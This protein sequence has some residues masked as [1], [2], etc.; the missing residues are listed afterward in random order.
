MEYPANILV[1]I[2][3]PLP[4]FRRTCPNQLD[5]LISSQV[6]AILFLGAVVPVLMHAKIC[7]SIPPAVRIGRAGGRA[8]YQSSLVQVIFVIHTGG[9]PVI[10]CDR[11]FIAEKIR[12]HAV[13]RNRVLA[14]KH[15]GGKAAIKGS[16]LPSG[17]LLCDGG[18]L[19]GSA[20]QR[21]QHIEHG[22]AAQIGVC[23]QVNKRAVKAHL[24]PGQPLVEVCPLRRPQGV[25]IDETAE[26]VLAAQGNAIAVAF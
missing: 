15:A 4:L 20:D 14:D 23:H 22:L 13:N 19:A 18:P 3:H 6:P 9:G 16:L 2:K 10:V 7:D 1:N 21:V 17:V 11:S 26:M 5:P 12:A 24:V 8:V 25:A